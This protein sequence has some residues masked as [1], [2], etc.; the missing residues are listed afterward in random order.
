MTPYAIHNQIDYL[1][2]FV[3]QNPLKTYNVRCHIPSLTNPSRTFK[4]LT[5]TPKNRASQTIQQISLNSLILKPNVRIVSQ[6]LF[7]TFFGSR[8]SLSTQRRMSLSSHS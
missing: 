7:V 3:M 8:L 5:K 1:S 6:S 4:H 2:M